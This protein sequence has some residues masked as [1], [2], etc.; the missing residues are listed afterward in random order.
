LVK[1]PYITFH[2]PDEKLIQD[3]KAISEPYKDRINLDIEKDLE[4]STQKA[5]DKKNG[6]EYNNKTDDDERIANEIMDNLLPFIKV[7]EKDGR[8]ETEVRAV[9]IAARYKLSSQ[10]AGRIRQVVKEK[11]KNNS[12]T[13]K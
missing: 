6:K 4:V 11:I 13:A 2:A 12:L 8:V 5:L 9:T 7:R 1:V 10:R 3:Y